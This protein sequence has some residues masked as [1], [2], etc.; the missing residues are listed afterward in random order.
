MVSKKICGVDLNGIQDAACRNWVLGVDGEEVFN[1]EPY[2]N[3]GSTNSSVIEVS[4]PKGPEYVGGIQADLAPHGRGGGY[5]EVGKK[6]LRTSVLDII[7]DSNPDIFKLASAL[8][9]LSPVSS[10]KIVS[11]ADSPET[12]EVYQ[13][14]LINALRKN[15]EKSFLLIWRSVLIALSEIQSLGLTASSRV[16]I[17]SHSNDGIEFQKLQIKKVPFLGSDILVPERKDPGKIKATSFGYAKLFAYAKQHF[18]ELT[19]D[20][21]LDIGNSRSA[22]FLALGNSPKPELL[23]KEN[24][25]WKLI[26]PTK[27]IVDILEPSI[28]DTTALSEYFLDCDRVIFETFAVGQLEARIRK[29]LTEIIDKKID[30]FSGTKVAEAALYAAKRL[31]EDSPIYLDF[32][33]QIST[34]VQRG[35]KAEEFHLIDQDETLR[36]GKVF[37]S[38]KPAQLAIQSGQSSIEVY[39]KKETDEQPRKSSLK[40][41]M[42]PSSSTPVFL[43]VEQTPALGRALIQVK[44]DKI[45]LNANLDWDNAEIVESTWP[46]LLNELGTKSI[47]IPERLV[48]EADPEKW[49]DFQGDGGLV[50]IL[51]DQAGK[52]SPNWEL[53]TNKISGGA[54]STD[55]STPD[56]IPRDAHGHIETLNI[57][58]LD[59]ISKIANGQ[60]THKDN[61]ALK[62]LTWQFKLCPEYIPQLLLNMF[63]DRFERT[64]TNP[65]VKHPRSWVL[66]FQGFGRAVFNPTLERLAIKKIIDFPVK[67]WRYR[68]QTACMSF[69]LSR[70]E[71]AIDFIEP[72]HIK[73]LLDRIKEEFEEEIGTPPGQQSYTKF[74]YAPGLLAGLLRYRIKEPHF[75]LLGVDP[76][77]KEI[78]DILEKSLEDLRFQINDN[79][80]RRE[81]YHSFRVRYAGYLE[82]I[83]KFMKGDQ[84]KSTLLLD[85]YNQK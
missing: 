82:E 54:I 70:S 78:M 1:D 65:F 17:I 3:L 21:M 24:G 34:I 56:G 15:K 18:Q 26:S 69:L 41:Q 77:A 42:A 55:G 7:Q 79:Q 59:L 29:F 9:G 51:E 33:P 71:T 20:T 2:I 47:P 27:N 30:A 43:S 10:Y 68:E 25:D 32:L 6:E 14:A 44:A 75:L 52:L 50:K 81:S 83:Q 31:E 53:L 11:I 8:S 35:I 36:A 76:K 60:E 63:D 45:G 5:G 74:N 23:R 13:E 73:I 37:R 16:G 19:Q 28:E 46:E 66:I 4:T 12:T 80:R 85:I 72:S 57:K 61:E 64:G 49:E 39:L 38:K 62:F 84:G 48:K 22:A 40:L 67:D 58:A